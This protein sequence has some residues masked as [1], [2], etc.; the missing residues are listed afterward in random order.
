MTLA[1]IICVISLF[2]ALICLYLT[3]RKDEKADVKLRYAK[4][5][6]RYI[7]Q[8]WPSYNDVPTKYELTWRIWGAIAV[9]GLY[10]TNDGHFHWIT[11]KEFPYNPDDED[12]KAFAIR[13]AEELID[14]LKEK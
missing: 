13:E 1:T 7:A 4:N 9:N 11:I 2:G 6:E 5:L 10:R 3:F 12:D 8:S 14:K